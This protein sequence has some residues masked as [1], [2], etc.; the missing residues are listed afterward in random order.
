MEKRVTQYRTWLAAFVLA[1]EVGG[2]AVNSGTWPFWELRDADFRRLAPGMTAAQAEGILGRP[3]LRLP[4]PRLAEEVWEYRYF[5]AQTPMKLLLH[6]DA[7]GVLKH[8]TQGFDHEYHHG[9]A[10]R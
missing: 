3:M 8:Y 6:F 7:E 5:D 1:L 9:G 4:L 10:E 2:C